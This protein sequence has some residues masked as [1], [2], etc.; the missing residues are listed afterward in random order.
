MWMDYLYFRC[1]V[2]LVHLAQDEPHVPGHLVRGVA[3]VGNDGHEGG[4]CRRSESDKAN[5]LPEKLS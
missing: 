2:L 5:I 1:L 4:L 3:G